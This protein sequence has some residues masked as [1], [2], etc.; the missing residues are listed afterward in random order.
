MMIKAITLWQPWASFMALDLKKNETRSW[1]TDY[2]GPLAIAAAAREPSAEIP[3]DV[4]GF[5]IEKLGPFKSWPRGVILCV[6]DLYLTV[7]DPFDP[8]DPVEAM[9]GFYGR[10]R[11]AWKTKLLRFFDDPIPVKGHQGLWDWEWPE[12]LRVRNK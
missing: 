1:G 5:A 6:R 11:V 4:Y 3:I 10:G 12:E 9:L 8:V 7:Y 2:R